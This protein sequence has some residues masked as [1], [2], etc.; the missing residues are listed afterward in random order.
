MAWT[1]SIRSP[2]T[3]RQRVPLGDVK[4]I[5]RR[6]LPRDSP[7]RKLL[8]AQPESLPVDVFLARVDDWLSL[9]EMGRCTAKPVEREAPEAEP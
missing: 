2:M 4:A 5:A 1:W 6:E 3:T 8:L 7:L 9:L